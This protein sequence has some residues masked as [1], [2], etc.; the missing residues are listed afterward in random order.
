MTLSKAERARRAKLYGIAKTRRAGLDWPAAREENT[1]TPDKEAFKWLRKR[2]PG[3]SD[4]KISH[5]IA[6]SHM[7]EQHPNWSDA[8]IDREIRIMSSDERPPECPPD[9]AVKR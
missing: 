3:W 4:E 1:R 5:L 8:R 6:R 7:I 2:N 9:P